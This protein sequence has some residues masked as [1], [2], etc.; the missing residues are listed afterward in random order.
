MRW[1]LFALGGVVV[2]GT[3]SSVLRTLV[4]PRALPSRFTYGVSTVIWRVLLAF[5]RTTDDY[6]RK[7]RIL[8]V[9]API[10]LLA[11]L[12]TWLSTLIVGYGFL[13][14]PFVDASVLSV[15]RDTGAAL[16]TLNLSPASEGFAVV[17]HLVAG[18]TGLTVVALLIAYLP[19]LYGAFNRREMLVTLLESRAGAPAWGPELLVRHQLVD[20][21]DNLPTLYSEWERWSADVAETHSTYPVLLYFRSP[22][23]MQSW[24]VGL[25]AVLDSAA[26]YLALSPGAAP[27]E[28]RLCLRMGFTCLRDIADVIGVAY[29]ADPDPDEDIRL[30][31]DEFSEGVDDLNLVGFPLERTAADAWADFRG[32]RVNYEQLAYELAD[33]IV[34]VPALWSGPRRHVPGDAISPDRPAHRA[35]D[36][37]K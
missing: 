9:G 14:L 17:V 36:G 29:N 1:V 25:L 15:L 4:V 19:T 16:L 34:A 24:L 10:T 6:G 35:P 30:T 22:N 2:L 37:R 18:A 3:F 7:D 28:A 13:A 33:R 5:S 8:T 27:S 32:W 12:G 11:L 31:F 21:T 26:M 23:P 20:I